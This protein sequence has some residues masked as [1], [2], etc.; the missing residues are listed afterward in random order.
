MKNKFV[1]IIISIVLLNFETKAQH[2]TP[3][4]QD[5]IQKALV[6]GQK[7]ATGAAKD[8]LTNYLQVA[9][10]N[11]LSNNSN[12]Q[13]KL[14][15]FALNGMDSVTKYNNA[16]YLRT[17]WQRNLE[18]Q[19]AVGV[20]K[21]NKFNSLKAGASYNVLNRRDVKMAY[22]NQVY[23]APFAEE[24]NILNSALVQFLPLVQAPLNL[25]VTQHLNTL[26]AAGNSTD[27]LKGSIAAA[28]PGIFQGQSSDDAAVK[29]LQEQFNIEINNKARQRAM[30]AEMATRIN[31]FVFLES[32]EIITGPLNEYIH[33]LGKTPLSYPHFLTAAQT[34]TIVSYIDA[35]VAANPMLHNLGANTLTDLN[36]K[37]LSNYQEMANYI[38]RQPLGTFNYLYSYGKGSL[39]SSHQFGFTYLQGTG[40]IK[41]QKQGQIIASLTDTLTSDDPTGVNRNLKR[42]IISLQAG[43]NQVLAMREK[44]SVMEFNFAL[45][46]D[47][48]TSGYVYQTNKSKFYL[49]ANFR[50][51][52]PSTPWLKFNLKY[53]PKGGNVFGFFDFTYNLDK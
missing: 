9:A 10:K 18:F 42:N 39:S 20:D 7:T 25:A 40:G 26:Y 34:M 16:N 6:N 29:Y 43:Y 1:M 24:Q 5:S 45:E 28:I 51:R 27:D 38:G 33:S 13:L 36:K 31:R 2:T 49:D 37:V 53:A 30:S 4:P 11:L 14:S 50:A 52:L 12:L 47:W 15:Y 44:V 35:Q 23:S 32:A 3:V 17:W 19:T 46:Q 48:A 22:F 8:I 41:T 21:N